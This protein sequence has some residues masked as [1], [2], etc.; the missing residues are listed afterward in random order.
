MIVTK[1]YYQ[2]GS[3]RRH[4]W[5]SE[6]VLGGHGWVTVALSER[7]LAHRKM[8]IQSG[9]NPLGIATFCLN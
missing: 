3:I 6:Y 4:F 9:R 5:R 1:L 7:D 8:L 2:E